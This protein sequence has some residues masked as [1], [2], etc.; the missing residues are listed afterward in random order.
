[1]SEQGADHILVNQTPEYWSGAHEHVA[2]VRE[3]AERDAPDRL[4][5]GVFFCALCGGS[6]PLDDPENHEPACLWRRAKM[7]YP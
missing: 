6:E 2:I 7:L 3:L 4:L 5:A 1:M